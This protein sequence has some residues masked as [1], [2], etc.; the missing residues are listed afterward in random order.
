[1]G[2]FR[3]L[4]DPAGYLACEWDLSRDPVGRS[5]WVEFFPRHLETILRV[6][7]EAA[8]A[9]GELPVSAHG[10]AA[11]CREEFIDHFDAYAREPQRFGRVT[12]LTLDEW[13][14]QILRRHGFV[15]P[16][17]DVKNRENAK[18]LPLLA[19]VCRE[20]DALDE[21]ARLRTT[22]QGLFAGNIFDMGAAATARA[23]ASGS[24]DF[25]NTR[26]T[27]PKRPWL[28]DDYDRLEQRLLR[29]PG[30]RVAVF[31]IDNAGSDFVLGALPLARWLAV[32]GTRVVLAANERPSLNDMTIDDVRLWW[33][34]VVEQEPTFARLPVELVS[35][36][37]GEPLIDLSNVSDELNGASDDADLVIL[38]GMGRGVESNLDAR[39]TCDALNVA[40]IKDEMVAARN[41]GKVFDL[42]CRFR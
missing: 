18:M 35:T 32:R 40:M 31:F 28:V 11:S 9:R 24:P 1:M 34:S 8:V 14:D 20:L 15:D 6:G 41:G 36:G 26:A 4:A 10:R 22:M 3:K 7:V 13:R 29:A 5:Y 42:V 37:T 21:P 16:F 2:A 30:H 38:E 23:F 39:F 12:I 27:L 33:P 25:F 17:I 19:P